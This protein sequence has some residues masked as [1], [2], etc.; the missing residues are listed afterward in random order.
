MD[1]TTPLPA[2]GTCKALALSSW[3]GPV[4]V[5]TDSTGT[6]GIADCLALNFVLMLPMLSAL[7]LQGADSSCMSTHPQ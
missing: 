3:T 2:Q 4:L 5:S 7:V 1:P 6:K